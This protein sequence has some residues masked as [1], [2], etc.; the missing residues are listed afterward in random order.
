MSVL[1]PHERARRPPLTPL[2]VGLAVSRAIREAAPAVEP[3][4]KWPN[5]VLV[6]GRKVC[7][8]LCEGE[9]EA[10]TVAGVGINV[11]GDRGSLPPD[12]QDRATTLEQEAAG[13]LLRPKL[14]GSLLRIL[15]RLLNPIP[16]EITGAVARELK[17]LD[18]LR[19]RLL[20]TESGLRGRG[21]GIAPD[22]AL[23]VAES[24]GGVRRVVAGS[25]K[26][27]TGRER[28]DS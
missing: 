2:L 27:Q 18:V 26:L 3:G 6:G 9:G 12:L 4:I 1:L 25:V 13:E 28:C 11:H 17:E 24:D 8:I 22:G 19:G 20:E 7:G 23:L 5:D 14:A 15:R 10:G 21:A 16:E